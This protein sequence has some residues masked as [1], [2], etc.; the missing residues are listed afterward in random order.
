MAPRSG[1]EPDPLAVRPLEPAREADPALG[2]L[3][4]VGV[5]P[6]VVAGEMRVAGEPR[7]RVRESVDRRDVDT[8]G[9]GRARGSGGASG[10]SPRRGTGAAPARS[11]RPTARPGDPP[12]RAPRRAGR[13]SARSRRPGRR[14]AAGRRAGGSRANAPARPVPGAR[15]PAAGIF[16]R[17]KAPTAITTFRAR[18]SPTVVR[19]RNRPPRRPSMAVETRD[20]DPRPDVG[21]DDPRVG[22]RARHDLVAGQEPAG[23]RAVIREPGQPDEL[24]RRHEAEGVPAVLPAAAERR[25]PL[26]DHVLATGLTEVPAGDQ[27]GVPRADDD[28]L[29]RRRAVPTSRS[30]RPRSRVCRVAVRLRCRPVSVRLTLRVAD[31]RLRSRHQQRR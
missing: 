12:R 26:E 1:G 23:I 4:Q 27:P 6:A 13:R 30:S 21:A 24:V 8:R 25:S 15:E 2:E 31:R 3:A 22:G 19:S 20:L 18:N 14:R 16:G 5:V 11:G 28:G 10:R 7:A 17:W 9:R 29:D